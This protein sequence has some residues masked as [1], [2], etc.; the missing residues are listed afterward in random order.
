MSHPWSHRHR[1]FR[2][3]M[4]FAQ[5]HRGMSGCFF[6][7]SA[8]V[9]RLGCQKRSRPHELNEPWSPVSLTVSKTSLNSMRCPPNVPSQMLMPARGQS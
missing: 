3:T 4:V 9:S 2:M 8:V 6:T 7:Q 1:L 5:S